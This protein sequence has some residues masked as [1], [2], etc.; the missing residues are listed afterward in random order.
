MLRAK[1]SACSRMRSCL[2]LFRM[3]TPK[4]ASAQKGTPS[5]HW[6]HCSPFNHVTKIATIL[7]I[8]N[9]KDQDLVTSHNGAKG[10]DPGIKQKPAQVWTL[11]AWSALILCLTPQ[12]INNRKPCFR[13]PRP[14]PR[15]IQPA[16]LCAGFHAVSRAN[17][18]MA[19]HATVPVPP[20][21]QTQKSPRLTVISLVLQVVPVPPLEHLVFGYPNLP[22]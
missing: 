2:L 1:G 15:A 6:T 10:M 17:P 4:M 13:S 14:S 22:T 8:N 21:A 3:S 9:R 18:I 16:R 7:M 5:N 12:Q 19:S 20:M 11:T